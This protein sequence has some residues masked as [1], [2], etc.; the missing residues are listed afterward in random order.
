MIKSSVADTW[1]GEQC[2]CGSDLCGYSFLI[3][4]PN[5]VSSDFLMV[6]CNRETKAIIMSFLHASAL[7]STASDNVVF[8]TDLLLPGFLSPCIGCLGSL[9]WTD[10]SD[11]ADIDM[12]LYN[13][14]NSYF[15]VTADI[16]RKVSKSRKF[17]H[18][19]YRFSKI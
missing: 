10:F 14:K 15:N 12:L 4:Y 3:S 19:R 17:G 2:F 18:R 13:S 6:S 9:G 7:K 5:S 16:L 1:E 8:W 11:L